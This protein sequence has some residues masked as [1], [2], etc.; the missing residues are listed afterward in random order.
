LLPA[1][2]KALRF[3]FEHSETSCRTTEDNDHGSHN[4]RKEFI[5]L[6]EKAR[7]ALERLIESLKY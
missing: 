6:T 5:G 2:R 7:S 1:N 3:H 4:I